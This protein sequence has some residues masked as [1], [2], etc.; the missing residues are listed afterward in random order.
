MTFEITLVVILLQALQSLS[1]NYGVFQAIFNYW[2]DKVCH[3]LIVITYLET[4]VVLPC[5]I[6]VIR[7]TFQMKN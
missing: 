7:I 5:I 4:Y 1:I 6:L 3:S 2:K